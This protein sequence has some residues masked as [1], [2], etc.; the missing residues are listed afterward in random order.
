M[1]NIILKLKYGVTLIEQNSVTGLSLAGH[2]RLAKDA[3]QAALIQALGAHEQPLDAL[4]KLVCAHNAT[5]MID[6]DTALTLA[7]FILDFEYYIKS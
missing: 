7:A 1:E 6:A 5:L 4:Q 2:I 3:Q